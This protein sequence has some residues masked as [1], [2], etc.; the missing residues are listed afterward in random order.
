[1]YKIVIGKHIDSLIFLTFGL[2]EAFR[3]LTSDPR[4]MP[5]MYMIVIAKPIDSLIFLPFGRPPLRSQKSDPR[6]MAEMCRI[7]IGKPIDSLIFLPLGHGS[8][9]EPKIGSE[10]DARNVQDCN[11]KT[12]RFVDFP[13]VWAS[14]TVSEPKIKSERDARCRT[15]ADVLTKLRGGL[16]RERRS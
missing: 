3:S 12:Y 11:C 16:R 13:S 4:G 1:M 2:P 8:F 15:R 7:V 6:G 9:S 10:R 5:E 14:G